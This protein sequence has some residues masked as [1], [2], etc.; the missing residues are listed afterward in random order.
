MTLGFFQIVI[1]GINRKYLDIV[2]IQLDDLK[3]SN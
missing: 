3:K 1:F 2:F